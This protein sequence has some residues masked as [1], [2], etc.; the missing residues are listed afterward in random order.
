MLHDITHTTRTRTRPHTHT[1]TLSSRFFV[2]FATSRKASSL[3]T[4]LSRV[5]LKF[6]L[7]LRF[8]SLM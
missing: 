7:L 4:S 2:F 8:F 5:W 3:V 1:H 6:L